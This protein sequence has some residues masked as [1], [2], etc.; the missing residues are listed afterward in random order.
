MAGPTRAAAFSAAPF[1]VLSASRGATAE[2]R[3]LAYDL[4][5]DGPVTLVGAT[6]WITS[7]ATKDTLAPSACRWCA[8]NGLDLGVRDALRWGDAKGADMASNVIGFAIGPAAVLGATAIAAGRDRALRGFLVDALVI[9]EAVVVAADVN[10]TVKLLAARDRPLM[11]ARTPDELARKDPASDDHL[12]FYSGHTTL[13]FS[14]VT[15]AGTVATMRGYR[16]APLVWA[17]GAP[18]AFVTPWLRMA[19][20]KHWFTDVLVGAAAG[21]AIGFAL[22]FLAHHPARVGGATVRLVPQGAGAAVAGAW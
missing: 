6:L 19:A 8:T 15:A 22:P 12:S 9:A 21:A 3:P 10:Q 11:L 18:F 2:P 4:D 17:V 14:I 1:F 20:D 13:A 5:V 7:E 16:W